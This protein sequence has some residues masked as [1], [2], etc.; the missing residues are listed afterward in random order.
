IARSRQAWMIRTAGYMAILVLVLVKAAVERVAD[1]APNN[2]G[3]SGPAW[4]GEIVFLTLMAGY[5]A[6]ILTSTASRSPAAPATVAVGTMVGAAVGVVVVVLGPLGGP[7]RFTGWWPVHLYD[8]A[9]ALGAL[10]ALGAPV[11][12]GLAAT[13]RA[14]GSMLAAS[15]ARQAAMAGLCTG[16]T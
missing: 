8:S 11:A 14:S 5:A 1:A 12:A 16:M 10:L 15:R 7:I 4:M 6:V 9:M 2:L 3:A 13:R